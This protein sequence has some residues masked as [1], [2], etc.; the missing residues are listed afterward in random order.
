M[1]KKKRKRL[2][3]ESLTKTLRLTDQLSGGQR[4]RIASARAMLKNPRVLIPDEARSAL[5]SESGGQVQEALEELRRGRRSVVIA[6]RLSTIRQADQILVLE[7]GRIIQK[8][9][10]QQLVEDTAGLYYSFSELQFTC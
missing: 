8:G 6:H 4:Q 5:D 7:Q 9:T 2:T 3:R 10:H 1:T